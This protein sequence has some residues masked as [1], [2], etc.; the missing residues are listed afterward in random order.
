[1]S[2]DRYQEDYDSIQAKIERARTQIDQIKGAEVG[3]GV[4]KERYQLKSV[5]TQI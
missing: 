2:I 4:T 5:W 1:M 3:K